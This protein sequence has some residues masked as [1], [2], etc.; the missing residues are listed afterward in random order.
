[1]SLLT[2]FLVTK[3]IYIYFSVLRCNGQGVMK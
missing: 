2:F 3:N 1:L